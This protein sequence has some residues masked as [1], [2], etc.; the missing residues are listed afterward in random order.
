MTHCLL[1]L[2][3]ILRLFHQIYFLLTSEKTL[4]S[5]TKYLETAL[6]SLCF[7]GTYYNLMSNGAIVRSLSIIIF[8]FSPSFSFYSLFCLIARVIRIN[9]F[10]RKTVNVFQMEK[11]LYRIKCDWDDLSDKTELMILK[12]YAA[13][14]RLCT[15]II[16]GKYFNP[17]Y[18]LYVCNAN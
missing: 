15:I 17:S 10:I 7:A 6:P 4:I 16:A 8:H 14:S 2:N 5:I 18:I 12:K 9:Y 1:C 13:V 3:N 11:I